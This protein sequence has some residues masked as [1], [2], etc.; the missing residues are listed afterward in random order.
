[1]TTTQWLCDGEHALEGG[2][3][4]LTGVRGV[5]RYSRGG[6]SAVRETLEVC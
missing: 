6:P 4:V 3:G 2:A 1:M 5:I